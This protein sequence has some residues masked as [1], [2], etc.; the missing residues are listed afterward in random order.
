MTRTVTVPELRARLDGAGELGLLDVREQGVHYRGHPFFA[1]SAPLSRLEMM[2]DD[3]VPR[4][5][6]PMVLLDA[7][8]E[9]LA[10]KAQARR[11]ELGYTDVY[12]R[13]GGCAA[14]KATQPQR[15]SGCQPQA[16]RVAAAEADVDQIGQHVSGGD[17][18][19]HDS[20]I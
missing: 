4:R 10:E 9:G 18:F 2:L 14:G 5:S 11:R 8:N 16:H 15:G 1:C 12:N 19:R 6:A 7:G 20:S 3:L 13:E 17:R